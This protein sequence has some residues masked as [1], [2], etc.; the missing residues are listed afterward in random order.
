MKKLFFV[1]PIA[2]VMLVS[3]GESTANDALDGALTESGDIDAAVVSFADGGATDGEQYFSGVLAEVVEVDVKL[4]EVKELDEMDA[5]EEEIKTV[6]DDAI[7]MIKDARTAMDLYSDKSW[8]KRSEL[9][10]ITLEWFAVVEA[11]MN[12]Y[13]YDLAEPMSRPDDT[14][15]DE[16]IAFY[17]QYSEAYEGFYEV[18]ERWVNFQHEYAAANGFELSGTIDEESMVNEEVSNMSH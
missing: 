15:T 5:T 14:W 18:D 6:L 10:D 12:D 9:H 11:L 2:S 13:L 4:R 16:E 8:P 17:E 1:L 7:Q 3:C